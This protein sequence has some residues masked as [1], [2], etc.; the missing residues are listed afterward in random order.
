MSR[1]LRIAAIFAAI[2]MSSAANAAWHEARSK[3]FVIY[4]DENPKSL[5]EYAT[6]LEQFDAAV[7]TILIMNDPPVGDGNRLTVYVMPTDNDVRELAGDKSGF[8]SGFYKGPAT[9]P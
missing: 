8:L 9:G 4:A 7:R 1:Y 3:H 5:L 2:S 6:K